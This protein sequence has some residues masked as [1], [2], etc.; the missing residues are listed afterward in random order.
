[1]PEHPMTVLDLLSQASCLGV[2]VLQ[3][4]DNMPL[5]LLSRAELETFKAEANK[6]N[7]LLEVGTRG[8]DPTHLRRYLELAQ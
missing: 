2:G 3:V 8:I 7:V 6:Q 5:D 4:A 1:M